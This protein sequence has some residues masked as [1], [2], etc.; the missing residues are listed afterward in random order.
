MTLPGP[1]SRCQL[2]NTSPFVTTTPRWAARAVRR[3]GRL[4]T[5]A[6]RARAQAAGEAGGVVDVE[7]AG[8]VD[9]EPLQRA[10]H[11]MNVHAR[12]L[13]VPAAFGRVCMGG[14]RLR[15]RG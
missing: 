2:T 12:R 7:P 9:L 13:P 3:A 1:A 15:A 5:R 14:L 4:R 6:Y 10:A 11:C 8:I